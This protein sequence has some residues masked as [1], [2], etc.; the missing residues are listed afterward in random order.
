MVD[1]SNK[2]SRGI[3]SPNNVPHFATADENRVQSD[4]WLDEGQMKLF[5]NCLQSRQWLG[6]GNVIWV[7]GPL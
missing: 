3:P 4:E 2:T 6:P 7:S 1:D 5:E